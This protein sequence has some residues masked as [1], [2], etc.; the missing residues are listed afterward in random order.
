MSTSGSMA[1]SGRP[2][3]WMGFLYELSLDEILQ[4]NFKFRVMAG[5]RQIG[6]ESCSEMGNAADRTIFRIHHDKERSA[7]G[8]TQ[9]V[10]QRGHGF[11][12]AIHILQHSKKSILCK[13][14]C[15]R[16]GA[17]RY[18]HA[19]SAAEQVLGQLQSVGSGKS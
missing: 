9:M 8:S 13:L 11:V 17:F 4:A 7:L 3:T 12:T 14:C 5:K 16:N 2:L 10:N 6:I 1:I 15:R 18:V 19:K